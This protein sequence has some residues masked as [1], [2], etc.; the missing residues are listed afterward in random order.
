[1]HVSSNSGDLGFN[2][3]SRD[4]EAEVRHATSRP[5]VYS[6]GIPTEFADHEGGQ[7]P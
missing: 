4:Q 2:G 6:K 7:S 5:F 3:V 1:M